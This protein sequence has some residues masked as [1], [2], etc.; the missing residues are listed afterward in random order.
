MNSLKQRKDFSFCGSVA[1]FPYCGKMKFHCVARG[2]NTFVCGQRLSKKLT[3]FRW[4]A[5]VSKETRAKFVFLLHF[6]ISFVIQ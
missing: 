4:L 6:Q 5:R 1:F 3:L 2:Q